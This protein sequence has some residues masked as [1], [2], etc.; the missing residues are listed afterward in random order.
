MSKYGHYQQQ[1]YGNKIEFPPESFLIAGISFYKD[2]LEGIN[3]KSLLKMKDE[4]DNK[5]DSTA[6]QIIFNENIIG[7]VPNKGNY[8]KLCRENLDE[9]LIVINIKRDGGNYGV[10]VILKKFFK[11]D[12]QNLGIF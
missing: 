2:N 8:K 7:Y 1:Y 3:F 10:R 9:E 5:F 12:Q 6:I 11:E 4:P